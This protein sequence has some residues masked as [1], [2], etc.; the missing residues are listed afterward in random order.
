MPPVAE[1]YEPKDEV[2]PFPPEPPV[3]VPAPPPPLAIVTVTVD[4]EDTS[5]I[6]IAVPPAPPPPPWLFELKQPRWW[7]RCG[8]Y[9]NRNY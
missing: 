9:C 5:I 2:V 8:W 1:Q 3:F 6:S 4:T 7:W